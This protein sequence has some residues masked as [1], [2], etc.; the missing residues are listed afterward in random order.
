MSLYSLTLVNQG[1]DWSNQIDIA[2]GVF[3][4]IAIV[5][6]GVAPLSMSV[7]FSFRTNLFKEE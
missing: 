3:A 7:Y 5:I 1:F 4:I 6:C 2:Q